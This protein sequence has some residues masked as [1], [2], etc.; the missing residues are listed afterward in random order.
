MALPVLTI[1]EDGHAD[2]AI[3]DHSCNNGASQGHHAPSLIVWQNETKNILHKYLM[4]N[5][6]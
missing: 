5:L 4:I 6:M 1:D 2:D 3:R